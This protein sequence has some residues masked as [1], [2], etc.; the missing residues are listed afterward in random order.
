MYLIIVGAVVFFWIVTY[1]TGLEP[2]QSSGTWERFDDGPVT[3]QVPVDGR[4]S[5]GR[6]T[7]LHG[8]AIQI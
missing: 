3:S 1:K 8:L 5:L 6:A 4:N 2:M 7:T